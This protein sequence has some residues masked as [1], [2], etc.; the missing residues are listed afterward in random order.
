MSFHLSSATPSPE[1]C[2]HIFDQTHLNTP[3]FNL[4]QT[5]KHF[6]CKNTFDTLENV[7]CK[8]ANI[9][10]DHN[11]LD[12]LLNTNVTNNTENLSPMSKASDDI[13]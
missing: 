9:F 6:I 1:Q 3:Q 7:I 13:W 4:N 8:I 5:K 11:V 12:K 2:P 10:S